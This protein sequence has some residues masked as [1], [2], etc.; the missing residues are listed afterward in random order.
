MTKKLTEIEESY[1]TELIVGLRYAVAD[2]YYGMI[3]L[4]EEYE[5]KKFTFAHRHGFKISSIF[6]KSSGSIEESTKD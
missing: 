2:H 6:S 3:K 1:R 4:Q 5:A